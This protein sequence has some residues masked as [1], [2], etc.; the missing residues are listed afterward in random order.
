MQRSRAGG[1]MLVIYAVGSAGLGWAADVDYERDVKPVLKAR[2]YACH[3]VL[4]QAAGLRLDTGSFIVRGGDGGTAIDSNQ[5]SE[6]RLL[7]RVSA[8]DSA[9]RM[10][11]EGEPLSTAQIEMLRAW[12]R[13]GTKFPESES[14]ETDPREHWAFQ[15]VQRPAVPVG[16]HVNARSNPIDAFLDL[17][18]AQHA[19]EPQQPAP[20]H[21]QLR[22]VYL[23]LIGLPPTAEE[24]NAFLADE[25]P[26]AYEV[27]V[28]RLLQDTRHG[29]R[30]ARHWMDV[31]RYSDWYGR[32]D[33]N[34]VRNGAG[35]LFRW[36]DWIVRSLNVGKGYDRMLQE[37]LAADE[38]CPDDFDAGVATGFLIRNYYSLNPN[39][40]LRS[41]VEHTGKAFLGLTFNCAHCHDHKYDPIEQDDYFRLRAF[42]EP[43]F[44]RQDRVPGE[45]DPGMFQL[46]DY[47]GS[48][49]VQRV[50][51]VR[52]YDHQ[53]DAPTW[54]YTGGDERNRV[55]ERGS[56]PPGVPAILEPA[57]L[58][59]EPVT[60]PP[61]AWYPGLRSEI[62][63]TML[64]DARRAV[65]TAADQLQTTPASEFVPSEELL[66]A[67]A[68]FAVARQ[69]AEASG[70]PAALIGEQSLLLDAAQGRAVVEHG[71]ESLNR[72][73]DGLTIS[74]EL[75]I[76]SN[77]HFN[78]QLVK[79]NKQGATADYVGWEQGR[80]QAY[81]TGTDS[82]VEIGKYDFAAGQSQFQVRL[83]LRP[84]ADEALV[85][86][87]S[88]PDGALLVDEVSTRLSGWTPIG[89]D[90]QT[91]IF[92]A[93]TGSVAVIDGVDVTAPAQDGGPPQ[94][95]LACD[96]ESSKYTNEGPPWGVDGWFRSSFSEVGGVVLVSRA[97]G[98]TELRELSRRLHITRRRDAAPQLR[99][100]AAV[101]NWAAAHAELTSLEARI[102]AERARYI[103]PATDEEVVGLKRIASRAERQ[104]Q[105]ARAES[106]LLNHDVAV[107]EAEAKSVDDPNRAKEL[108]AAS[109]L[110]ATAQASVHAARAALANEALAETYAPLSPQFPRQSTGRRKALAEWMTRRDHPLTARVAVNHI[111]LRHFRAPLVASMYDF[112]RNGS[113]P[114]HQKLL[115]W[116]AVELIDSGWDMKHLH[117]LIVTSDAYRR[118]SS[119]G[120]AA[121]SFE[122]DPENR[123]L[124]RM[125]AWRMESEVVRD[126][127]L[128]VAGRLDTT[129]GGVEL[130]NKDAL[131]TCRRTLYYSSHPESGGKS[132]IGELFDAPDPLDCYRRA[133]SI[134]PQQ[135]LALTNSE[136]V[137]KSSIAIVQSWERDAAHSVVPSGVDPTDQFIQVMFA[138][139]LCRSPSEAEQRVCREALDR[140][141]Q[142]AV[143]PQS[144][145]AVTMARESLVRIL[146]NHN[147]FITVR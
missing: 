40:W 103:S 33:L 45:A 34:D 11:P 41:T 76:L 56:I 58:H 129:Q 28:D 73:D 115:D 66:Q 51:A 75:R 5:P 132:P 106:S 26:N 69:Q 24:L 80:I 114:T 4:K 59:I 102:V 82:A 8:R 78:F 138:Q 29:E 105:L 141:Q 30:W 85:T 17:E 90:I 62:Q 133:S 89:N 135:A 72:F 112:G 107:L 20:S 36:R 147:D 125:N 31:W 71:L 65:A 52:V 134:V 121:H 47:G 74:F 42:F 6:S 21:V 9:E 7:Q 87:R 97:A 96:F 67:E 108:A 1:L 2:C 91:M 70:R 145:A 128:Y 27:V 139:I 118:A 83:M 38:L 98:N 37:M 84:T 99:H 46:Y 101:A 109:Q 25:S 124:W 94:K 130:E 143:D 49:L 57:A 60:L 117:R 19:I 146:L 104:A 142:L 126:S 61:V 86:V 144:A 111:W 119:V 55:K 12:I 137:Q 23:D 127:L 18:R 136:L 110:V 32:R 122:A 16:D 123:F 44:V 100:Q 120:T 14:P 43:I 22:R 113:R 81:K 64:A 77:A 3:G 54:F 93:R 15:S 63:E 131:T 13:D 140:Q 48:R 53:A 68:A 39:D 50:G 88:I 92:D 10:P 95:I 35:Q 79:D 116:L